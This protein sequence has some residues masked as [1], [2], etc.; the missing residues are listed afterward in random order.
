MLKFSNTMIV[1]IILIVL[2]AFLVVC[3]A[4][5]KIIYI[6]HKKHLFDEPFEDRKVHLTKTPN[7]GGVAIIAALIFTIS[8]FLPETGIPNINYLI[9]SVVILFSLG[10]TDDLVGVD[11]YKKF[12]AQI[13]VAVLVTVMAKIRVENLHGLFGINSI[14][15]FGSVSVS[16]LFIVFLMN[17]VNLIDGINGLAGSFGLLASIIFSYFFW[18]LNAIA[19]LYISLGMCGCLIGFLVY[20]FTP[21]RIFMGDTGSLFLGFILSVFCIK[22]INLSQ[23]LDDKSDLSVSALP[24]IFSI[25]VVPVVDTL[26]VFILRVSK[27]KSPF[28]ADRNHLH[29]ILLDLELSHLSATAIL[30]TANFSFFLL[31]FCLRS[32]KA[33]YL[34]LSLIAYAVTLLIILNV[35]K[36]SFNF[37]S[38]KTNFS[39][40]RRMKIIS[41]KFTQEHLI[42]KSAKQRQNI[43]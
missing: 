7:L 36:T 31:A 19:F 42:P 28:D 4:I 24:L 8:F 34:F 22:F 15:Y 20:N 10:I 21:A 30:I 40:Q 6:A 2:I 11:P 29:H 18:K 25:L 17:A 13:L 33:E 38:N 3:F 43:L 23:L 1:N 37:R 5:S 16:I 27:K 9:A 35:I 39:I 14:S 41:N 26:R 32:I 12:A